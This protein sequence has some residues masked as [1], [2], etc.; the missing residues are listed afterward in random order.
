M[1]AV[2]KPSPYEQLEALPEHVTGE[3]LN[4]ELYAMPRPKR[5]GDADWPA[6]SLWRGRPRR[7]VD[8]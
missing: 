1:P 3:I 7:L 8:H 2:P 5:A 6:V 4:G